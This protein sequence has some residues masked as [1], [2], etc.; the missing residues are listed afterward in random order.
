MENLKV[1]ESNLELLRIISMLLIVTHHLAVHTPFIF[2][3]I[4]IKYIVY[5]ISLGGKIGVALFVLLTGYL[6]ANKPLKIKNLFKIWINVFFYSILIYIFFYFYNKNYISDIKFYIFPITYSLYWFMT[7]Y[8]FMYII[9]YFFN[10]QI[11]NIERKNLLKFIIFLTF[12]F[13]IIPSF[14]NISIGYSSILW[15]ILLYLIGGYIKLYI[16]KTK[17]KYLYFLSFLIFYFII[18]IRTIKDSVVIEA[19]SYIITNYIGTDDFFI[20]L[21]SIFIILFFINLD[22]KYNIYINMIA[23]TTLG[24][25]LIHDHPSMRFLLWNKCFKLFEITQSKYLILNSIKAIFIVFFVC[26][27]ID[28]IRKFIVEVLLKKYVSWIYEKLVFL[29][30]KVDK[31]L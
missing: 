21:T 20:L 29:N 17:N 26:M 3:N 19:N 6:Q 9:L 23:S 5:F 28:L 22:I 27:I 16:K 12:F 14:F 13:S 31:I 8:F 10:F 11:F 18:F 30:E 15:F 7:S 4:H 2:E 24:I 25:Y 1:R